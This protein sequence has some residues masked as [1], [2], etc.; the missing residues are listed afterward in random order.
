MAR[1]GDSYATTQTNL[2]VSIDSDSAAARC[3]PRSKSWREWKCV[4]Q[5]SRAV[6]LHHNPLDGGRG[7]LRTS[8]STVTV[9]CVCQANSAR[10]KMLHDAVFHPCL[11]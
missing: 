10:V 4:M 3:H 6:V 7:Y 2:R 11:E 9:V 1:C 8:C 5:S